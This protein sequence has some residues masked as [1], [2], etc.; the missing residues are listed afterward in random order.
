MVSSGGVKTNKKKTQKWS[1]WRLP[2][3]GLWFKYD[4]T[5][6]FINYSSLNLALIWKVK[7]EREK[8]FISWL[9][10]QQFLTCCSASRQQSHHYLPLFLLVSRLGLFFG[11]VDGK[12]EEPCFGQNP[13]SHR[14]YAQAEFPQHDDGECWNVNSL[15]EEN[16][17]QHPNPGAFQPQFLKILSFFILH[18]FF[19]LFWCND[20]KNKFLKI[21][22]Y[23]FI[24]F[25]NKKHFKK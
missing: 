14:K 23:Y 9:A 6:W 18:Y 11:T 17:S 24:I 5:S 21:K 12:H 2:K 7:R 20:I 4:I 3:S 15:W 10:T 22:K 1:T 8:R 13:G 16:V 19:L 25:L